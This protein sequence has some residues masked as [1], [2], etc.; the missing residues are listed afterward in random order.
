MPN[1][2]EGVADPSGD[3]DDRQDVHE[4]VISGVVAQ[5]ICDRESRGR[6][7][8]MRQDFHTAFSEHVVGDDNA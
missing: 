1:D 6:Q 7:H 4:Q 3:E 5:L 8:E 2:N